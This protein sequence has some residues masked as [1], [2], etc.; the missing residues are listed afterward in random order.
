MLIIKTCFIKSR[1]FLG[2]IRPSSESAI[3]P[4]PAWPQDLSGEWSLQHLQAPPGRVWGII[5]AVVP[6]RDTQGVVP[7]RIRPDAHLAGWPQCDP[8]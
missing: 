7:A 2:G 8:G 4:G 6:I 5:L 3:L 1:V